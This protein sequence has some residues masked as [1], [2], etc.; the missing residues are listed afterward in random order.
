MDSRR[1]DLWIGRTGV[2]LGLALAALAVNGWAAPAGKAPT[3][4]R[5]TLSAAPSGELSVEP[6]R[7]FLRSGDLRAGQTVDGTFVITNQTGRRL[8]VRPRVAGLSRD[9][10]ELL[11]VR[12]SSEGQDLDAGLEIPAG[13]RRQVR[14]KLAVPS[15]ARGYE[16]RAADLRI[17]LRW[18]AA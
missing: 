13:G 2:L 14:A 10:V 11:D 3:G 6:A 5:V 12:L 9:L 16:Y 15:G 18:E 8:N 7:P 1:I 4:V 17:E